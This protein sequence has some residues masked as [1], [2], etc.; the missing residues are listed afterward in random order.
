MTSSLFLL[1][2][3]SSRFVALP[4]GRYY[5]LS[6]TCLKRPKF[7]EILESQFKKNRKVLPSKLTMKVINGGDDED[8]VVVPDHTIDDEGRSF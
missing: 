8:D 3:I 1:C 5:N 4:I 2:C 7:N 6:E